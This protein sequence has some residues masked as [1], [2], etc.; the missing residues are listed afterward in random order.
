MTAERYYHLLGILLIQS[1]MIP[2]PVDQ[3]NGGQILGLE[4]RSS[5][6]QNT[7]HPG[8][9]C[10]FWW[11]SAGLGVGNWSNSHA[12]MALAPKSTLVVISWLET[13]PNYYLHGSFITSFF[14]VSMI[15][16]LRR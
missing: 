15:D 7:H 11:R 14:S 4:S 12:T 5:F 6:V 1:I 9:L 3:P 2:A 10:S 16:L 13:V 8:G